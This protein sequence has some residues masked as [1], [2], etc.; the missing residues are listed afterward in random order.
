[1][2]Q[3]LTESRVAH[4]RVR[5]EVDLS[6]RPIEE[7]GRHPDR[8]HVLPATGAIHI[9]AS[10]SMIL[11]RTVLFDVF[12]K[13]ILVLDVETRRNI[14]A[15]GRRTVAGAML[16]LLIGGVL[17]SIVMWLLLRKI[18]L[19]PIESLAGH[20]DE[21][22]ESG[23]LLRKLDLDSD[24]EIG[25]LAPQFDNLTSEVHEARQALLDQSFKAGKADTVAEGVETSKQYAILR[26]LKCG[27]VQGYFIAKPMPPD[28]FQRWCAG[29]EETQSL[30]R[31]SAV[32]DIDS[33]R[34]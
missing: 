12:N 3:F 17:A 32:V 8:D 2:G 34:N 11:S 4:L 1:M 22:R 9:V 5:T 15:L 20:I 7:T 29:T 31:R 27:L 6:L 13:P 23:D 33:A 21:I 19:R 24:D 28:E 10:E 30:N 16:L 18:I 25:A 14:S 26:Q